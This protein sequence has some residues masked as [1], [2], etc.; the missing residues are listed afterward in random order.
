MK[1][2]SAAVVCEFNE[3]NMYTTANCRVECVEHNNN[4][5]VLNCE[6]T[7]TA[8]TSAVWMC[9]V[10][11][12]VWNRFII[13]YMVR[14][15][16]CARTMFGF[17]LHHV[18]GIFC[19][20]HFLCGTFISK[21]TKNDRNMNVNWCCWTA[22]VTKETE[23]KKLWLKCT[24]SAFSWKCQFILSGIHANKSPDAFSPRDVSLT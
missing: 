11:V 7:S 22:V 14:M 10:S 16:L 3:I 24:V 13:V 9:D 1:K 20:V 17:H 4:N 5:N 2:S 21:Q 8:T 12:S 23:K 18:F 19:F 15:M 6:N